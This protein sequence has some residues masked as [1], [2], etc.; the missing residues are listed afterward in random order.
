MDQTFQAVVT[1]LFYEYL[2]R[3]PIAPIKAQTTDKFKHVLP[4]SLISPA[5]SHVSFIQL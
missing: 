4:V 1:L 5:D 2:L 3:F